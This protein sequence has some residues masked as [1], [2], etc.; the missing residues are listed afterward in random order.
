MILIQLS[1]Y[2]SL[3]RYVDNVNPTD[4]ILDGINDNVTILKIANIANAMVDNS[5][6]KGKSD[7]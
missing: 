6:Y 4:E 1:L 3:C 2:I 7:T 5:Y